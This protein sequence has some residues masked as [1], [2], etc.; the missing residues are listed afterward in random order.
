MVELQRYDVTAVVPSPAGANKV[1]ITRAVGGLPEFLG[2]RIDYEPPPD[3]VR[4]LLGVPAL[5][6]TA[7]PI[8]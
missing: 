6:Q 5:T 3:R 2:D 1:R 4:S 7:I 8:V